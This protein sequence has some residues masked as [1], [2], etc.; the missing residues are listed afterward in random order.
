MKKNRNLRNKQVYTWQVS[1]RLFAILLVIA[2]LDAVGISISYTSGK[3]M[4]D[5]MMTLAAQQF[6]DKFFSEELRQN[7]YLSLTCRQAM[8]NV[9]KEA[10]YFP[11]PE[12]D[13]DK[14]LKVSFVD[15]WHMERN[16][17]G[18]RVHEGT[19]IMAA[20]NKR[21]LYPV[22]S[23]SE[24]YQG[25]QDGSIVVGQWIRLWYEYIIRGLEAGRFVFDVKK[26]GKA[27]QI[28]RAHV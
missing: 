9:E 6:R 14:S 17:G 2:L 5:R 7:K 1:L 22:V 3:H 18:K 23:V 25:I 28:G 12:S 20:E 26:A 13:L 27:I 15:T 11:I 4:T 8:Q 16:Y 19:D 21:G 24:Y 10:L